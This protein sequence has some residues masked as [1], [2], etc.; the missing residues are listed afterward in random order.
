MAVAHLCTAGQVTTA[1]R[2]SKQASRHVAIF[3]CERRVASPLGPG[4]KVEGASLGQIGGWWVTNT[5][6]DASLAQR[7]AGCCTDGGSDRIKC[8]N[9]IS[10]VSAKMVMLHVDKSD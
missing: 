6:N 8:E 10:A 7:S 4:G 5:N 2:A 9:D 1:E 3:T